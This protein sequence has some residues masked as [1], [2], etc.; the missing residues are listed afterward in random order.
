MRSVGNSSY[1]II[2]YFLY[3]LSSIVYFHQ[4]CF[5]FP[6]YTQRILFSIMRLEYKKAWYPKSAISNLL[7]TLQLSAGTY[8]VSW[9]SKETASLHFRISRINN[10]ISLHGRFCP[11]ITERNSK[12]LP[13]ALIN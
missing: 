12:S 5:I 3:P 11:N 13:T 9:I 7:L 10:F 8:Y 6:P 1:A 2:N 4:V